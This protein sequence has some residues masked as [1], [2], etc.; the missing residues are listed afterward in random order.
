MLS[1][2]QNG[3]QQGSAAAGLRR[4]AGDREHDADARGAACSGDYLASLGGTA[5]ETLRF[6]VTCVPSGCMATNV[7][8]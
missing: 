2:R 7:S 8:S 6:D 3:V 4:S 1:R 5:T